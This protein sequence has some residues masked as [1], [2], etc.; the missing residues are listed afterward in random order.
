MLRDS[1]SPVWDSFMK[2]FLLKVEG[3]ARYAGLLLASPE[4]LW[5]RL[6]D[7]KAFYAVFAYFRQFLVFSSNLSNF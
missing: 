3:T 6:F 4:S 2:L 7:K 5:L 1:V